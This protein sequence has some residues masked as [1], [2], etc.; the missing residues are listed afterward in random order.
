MQKDDTVNHGII[1][2]DALKQ[3]LIE[4]DVLKWNPIDIWAENGDAER[5]VPRY[6]QLCPK[7]NQRQ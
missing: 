5:I 1:E 2:D 7:Q 6:A 4:G 3:G